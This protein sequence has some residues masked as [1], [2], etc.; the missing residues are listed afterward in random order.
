M[1]VYDAGVAL[2]GLSLT[3]ETHCSGSIMEPLQRA[4]ARSKLI[5]PFTNVKSSHQDRRGTFVEEDYYLAC[6]TNASQLA[7]VN[8]VLL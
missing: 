2:L 1:F 3:K 5:L 4:L 8:Y 7:L 6:R